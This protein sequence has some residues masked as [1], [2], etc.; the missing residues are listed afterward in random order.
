MISENEQQI[1]DLIKKADAV[2]YDIKKI[3]AEFEEAELCYRG[4]K[5]SEHD[6]VNKILTFDLLQSESELRRALHQAE[7]TARL[8]PVSC[9]STFQSHQTRPNSQTTS[10][11][12]TPSA[13]GLLST[14]ETQPIL[15]TYVHQNS[16]HAHYVNPTG[17]N[18]SHLDIT[19]FT[20]VGLITGGNQFLKPPQLLAN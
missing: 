9:S 16:I 15:I 10:L 4:L 13:P 17:L 7:Q 5:S 18:K 8:G 3:R 1:L 2:F 19:F 12:I 11:Q 20:K 6:R 14:V